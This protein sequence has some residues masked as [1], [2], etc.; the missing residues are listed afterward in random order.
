MD[1]DAFQDSAPGR[2]VPTYDDAKA[3]VPD[4]IPESLE[5][6]IETVRR[7]AAAENAVGR[8]AGMTAREFN[9]YLIGSPLLHREAIVSSRMEG[10][11]TTPEQLVLLQAESKQPGRRAKSDD[12]TQEVLNYVHAM[13]RGLELLA[14]LPVCLR[15]IKETHRVLLSE[16][17]GERHR[18][19]EFRKHQNFIRGRGDDSIH[20]ARFVPPPPSEMREALER[21]EEYL[22]REQTDDSDPLLVQLALTHY[23]FETIHP[24]SDGNGRIGR[25]LIPLLMCNHQRLQA[26][27]LYVSAYLE[28]HREQYQDL[29]LHVSQTGDWDTWIGFF[30]EALHESAEEA[31]QQAT[32]LLDLRQRYHRQFQTS[33][34]SALLI[35]LIDRLFRVPSITIGE[36]SELLKVTHQGAANNIHKLEDAG[37]LKEVTGQ[38]RY[39]VYVAHEI[40]SIMY[41]A[42][43]PETAEP[44]TATTESAGDSE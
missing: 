44:P 28:Q 31:I 41:D 7:L 3:F 15:L 12:D 13:E 26:P 17:R 38:E 6:S 43:S 35:R 40:L 11:I 20:N 16:V 10:T 29:M 36:A 34:S 42:E 5:M 22:N 33:R 1:E 21:F 4:P 9:P 8:L 30:L 2:L 32:D 24:F 23:Q 39:K 25:L 19:G 18:P 37:I 27:I 14:D